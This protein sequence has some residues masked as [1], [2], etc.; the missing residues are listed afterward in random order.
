M[1]KRRRGRNTRVP[2]RRRTGETAWRR[3]LAQEGAGSER[4][5][6]RGSQARLLVSWLLAGVARL[7]LALTHACLPCRRAMARA[8]A[9]EARK[10]T[11]RRLLIARI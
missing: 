5:R 6:R 1:R 7:L 3:T 2:W 10:K 4:R 8:L 11:R 9:R